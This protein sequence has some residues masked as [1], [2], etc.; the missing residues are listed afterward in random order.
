MTRMRANEGDFV[1]YLT[2]VVV[3]ENEMIED[4]NNIAKMK[5]EN[6]LMSYDTTLC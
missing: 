2:C 5:D 4:L 3:G 6:L 1:H